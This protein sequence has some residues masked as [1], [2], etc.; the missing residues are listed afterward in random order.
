L[1]PPSPS[2]DVNLT[3]AIEIGRS[4]LQEREVDPEAGWSPLAMVRSEQGLAHDFVWEGGGEGGYAALLGSYL[5][6]PHWEVRFVRFDV[7]P[8]ERVEEY[9]V[10]VDATGTVLGVT[11]RLPEARPGENPEE[12][13]ARTVAEGVLVR[14]F[15]ERLSDFE[16]IGAEE[17]TR[18]SR[19]D[20]SFTY[21]DNAQPVPPPGEARFSVRLAGDEVISSGQSVHVPEDW[22]RARRDR[23]SRQ[24][25][26]VGGVGV[27][28]L[29]LFGAAVIAA[30]VRWSRRAL[31]T[32]P[33]KALGLGAAAL[34]GLTALNQWP[35]VAA[36]FTTTQPYG[37][38]AG[39]VAVGMVLFTMVLALSV[40]LGAGLAH[41][42]LPSRG[43]IAKSA[44]RT[45]LQVG[46]FAA[47]LLAAASLIPRSTPPGW[48]E[49]SS[50]ATF[51]PVLDLALSP[52]LTLLLGTTA[53]LLVVA[54]LE[55][56]TKGWKE[57]RALPMVGLLVLGLA[58][59]M[60]WSQESMILWILLG[61][62]GSAGIF[63]LYR[64][65]RASHWAIIPW[66]VCATTVAEGASRVWAAPQASN[67]VGGVVGMILVVAVAAR[68]SRGLA[69]SG[70]V[71]QGPPDRT[72]QGEEAA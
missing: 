57:R 28:V 1:R 71:D 47:G 70:R 48:P 43:A 7:P 35:S 26:L 67:V 15:G 38:Q 19:T 56:R 17:T 64:V 3:E 29:G 59:M 21:R 63:G 31:R 41:T 18:P 52:L 51:L 61:V 49:Y 20:W 44:P 55:H 23:A 24:L 69:V 16:E 33:L 4:A 2:L 22:A 27:L 13:E 60:S 14:W 11:H 34:S 40:G 6:V 72:V 68:W 39:A 32:G 50:A 53:L 45:G 46:V 36:G 37:L 25:L 66:I 42:W 10:L 62:T 58:F 65:T 8:E 54:V 9:R 5:S 30:I 12:A